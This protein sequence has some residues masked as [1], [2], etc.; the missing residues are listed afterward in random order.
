MALMAASAQSD[1][2]QGCVTFEDVTIYFSQEEW[3]LLD[4]AQRLLY[5]N[6][7]VENF[8]LIASLGF[9]SRTEVKVLPSQ[10]RISVQGMIQAG[11]PKTALSMQKA[12]SSD[13]CGLLVKEILYLD[14]E[15]DT[16]ARL[17]AH[18][19]EANGTRVKFNV[20]FAQQQ[21]QKHED[22]PARRE[23]GRASPKNT[24]ID[25]ASQKS[26][27][28]EERKE[29]FVT[30]AD[31][32]QCWITPDGEEAHKSSGETLYFPT[33]QWLDKS[34]QSSYTFSD[35]F[36]HV[37][38]QR[39]QRRERP[40]ECR[41]CGI[42]FS[43]PSIFIQHQRVHNR[44]KPYECPEC[45]RLFSQHSSLVRH[46]RVHT[47]E[48]PHVCSY[49]G[50]FFSRSSNLAQHKRVHTGERPFECSECGKFFSHLA[51]LIQ[52]YIVHTGER[53]FGCS[54]CGKAFSRSSD[55]I[56]HLRV[57]TGEQPYECTECGKFFSQSSSLNSHRRLHTGERP[58]QCNEC[59]KTFRQR[60]NLRQHQMI[61]R[62]DRPYQCSACGKAFNQR[63]SLMRHLKI[64]TRE[65][66]VEN[67]HPSFSAQLHTAEKGC[68]SSL[69]EGASA[70]C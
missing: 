24:C 57:H 10:Q 22:E 3:G 34:S 11:N 50:K 49:C 39:V 37:H 5:C 68:D 2:L 60:F 63:T 61:H 29:V 16:H 7:M 40:Y 9:C 45:G 65:S 32:V 23:E 54:A 41:K 52:H 18:M 67:V 36:T 28:C 43:D 66:N 21:V 26:F 14:E 30:T 27:I 59:G 19:C 62:P 64:H 35:T 47:G 55:L 56:K 8:T 4:E 58:F 31:F 6:V 38:P 48:S 53:P 46:H 44:G 51:S 42:F 17:K 33:A 1:L 25:Q 70:S 15:D 69:Y 20:N 13:T 12:Y